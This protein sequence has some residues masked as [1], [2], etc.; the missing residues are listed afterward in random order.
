M[1]YALHIVLVEPE[2]PQNTGNIVRLCSA[3]GATL[4]LVK[5]LGFLLEDKYLKRAGL[6]YWPL[7]DIREHESYEAF[8]ASVPLKKYLMTS[9]GRRWPTDVAFVPECCLLFGGE[10]KGLAAD[11]LQ[12]YPEDDLRLPMRENCRCLNLSNA[13]AVAA[14]E[15]M[16]Q[17]GY[18]RLH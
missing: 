6:D 8:E 12:R 5:P 13:V 7:V 10:T 4:H 11:I 1:S 16:R 14:Y 2:I 3:L 9:K 17:W 18:P 15:V